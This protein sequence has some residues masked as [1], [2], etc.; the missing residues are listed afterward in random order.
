MAAA[1]SQVR[2]WWKALRLDWQLSHPI[3]FLLCACDH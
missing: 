1:V 3:I 2:G